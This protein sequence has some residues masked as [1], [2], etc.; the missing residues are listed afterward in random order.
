MEIILLLIRYSIA[1]TNSF[2]EISLTA[3]HPATFL[4]QFGIWIS[5]WAEE[6]GISMLDPINE[7]NMIKIIGNRT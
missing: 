6:F 4:I 2:S 7:N 5:S 1:V 3:H